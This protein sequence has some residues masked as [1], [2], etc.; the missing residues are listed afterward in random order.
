M[1]T[2][3][4]TG[5]RRTVIKTLIPLVILFALV[6]GALTLV[7]S[8]LPDK[9]QNTE[10]P[11]AG[12]NGEF[13]VGAVAPDFVLHKF[14][15]KPDEK[16]V[17]LSELKGK[18]YLVNFW[19]T[20]CTAC[21]VEMPSIVQLQKSFAP[22][23]LEVVAVNVDEKP[24][25]VLPKTLKEMKIEFP[26]FVDR[27]ARLSELFDVHAIPLTVILDSQRKVLMIQNG[28]LDWNSTEFR[29]KMEQWLSNS[30]T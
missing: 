2:Q 4:E 10:A 1:T 22:K 15:A 9:A 25:A 20:W 19:A 8:Q 29:G 24:E 7:K 18:I 13:K 17:K 23:G 5:G 26:V 6:V 11:N 21:M 12:D 14:G 30:K 3:P 27:D 16:P 28:E